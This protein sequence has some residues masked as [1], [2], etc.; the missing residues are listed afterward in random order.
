MDALTR[1]LVFGLVGACTAWAVAACNSV[2]QCADA[3]SCQLDGVDGFC[4][5]D[6]FCS[7]PDD[8]CE[9]HRRYGEFAGNDLSG[10]CVLPTGDTDSTSSSTSPGDS[11]LVLDSAEVESTATPSDSSSSTGEDV[12][13][14]ECPAPPACTRFVAPVG[15]DGPKRGSEDAPLQTIKYA[16]DNAVPGDVIC[17]REGDYEPHVEFKTSGSEGAPIVLR[18]HPGETARLTGGMKIMNTWG[19]SLGWIVIEELDITQNGATNPEVGDQCIYFHSAHDVVLRHNY[20]HDCNGGG[21]VGN[22]RDLLVDSNRI[23][24]CALDVVGET[25]GG[26]VSMGGTHIVVQN[27]RIERNASY[28]VILS[29]EPWDPKND[30]N[31]PEDASYAE[32]ADWVVTNNVFAFNQFGAG[33]RVNNAG[34][35]GGVFQNNIFFENAESVGPNGI[36]FNG[37]GGHVVRNNLFS[38]TAAAMTDIGSS[39]TESNS[40]FE[41][42]LFLDQG[43]TDFR[44]DSGSPAIDGG[45][46]DAAPDHDTE[47]AV[48]PQGAAVDLGVYEWAPQ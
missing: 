35:T 7:F 23:S 25:Y 4:E 3:S 1:A 48:R 18:S 38:G 34:A 14:P 22:A 46:S 11:T 30:L 31:H 26:G 19:V 37:G 15:I 41:D 27:N 6:G 42:P 16:V 21:L 10:K 20:I 8:D 45:V 40:M 2:F 12:E 5:G 43:G 44:V 32:A 33:I 29:A 24:R 39:Y 13:P 17:L 47:C 28:G 9:S 36:D